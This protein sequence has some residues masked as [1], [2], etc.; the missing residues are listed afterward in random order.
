M[1]FS[2]LIIDDEPAAREGLASDVSDI[3]YMEVKGLAANAFQAFELIHSLAP[4]VIFLDIN[5]PG[6]SG[7]EFLRLLKTESQ[8][9]LTTAYRDYALESYELAV[10]DYLLKPISP[11]RLRMATNKLLNR[12]NR[13]NRP[14]EEA[15]QEGQYIFLKCNGRMERI[16][17]DDILYFEGANNY[18]F[19]HTK[20]ARYM[21]Y[22]TLKGI[23]LQLPAGRFIKVHKSYII[24]KQHI[25]SLGRDTVRINDVDIPLSRTFRT[26]VKKDVIDGKTVKRNL[27]G[28]LGTLIGLLML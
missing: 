24:S 2:A 8:V 5:L 4:A 7:L 18:V 9:I 26:E 11:G 12:T 22:I 3:P 21:S 16:A 6:M 15:G 23:E 19:V 1:K 10:L 13:T 28:G 17:L 20:V 27:F 14:D 25:H